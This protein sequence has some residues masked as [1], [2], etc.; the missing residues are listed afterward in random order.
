MLLGAAMKFRKKPSLKIGKSS[1]AQTLAKL[2]FA[3][4]ELKEAFE[5]VMRSEA[6]IANPKPWESVEAWQRAERLI[7]ADDVVEP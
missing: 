4:C 5:D 3:L 7:H 2:E 6:T 1:R